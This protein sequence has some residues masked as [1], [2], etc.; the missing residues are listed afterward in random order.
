M[1]RARDRPR[2]NR[3]QEK[4]RYMH[5]H[6]REP[7]H[8]L[9]TTTKKN[10]IILSLFDLIAIQNVHVKCVHAC[11]LCYFFFFSNCIATFFFVIIFV[12]C[13]CF[14]PT[15][16]FLQYRTHIFFFYPMRM[17]VARMSKSMCILNAES[18][19]AHIVY[20]AFPYLPFA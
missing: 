11:G 12:C 17:I 2:F 8:P 20:Y 9:S 15:A 10:G 7:K 14:F 18:S 3:A 19:S 4:C 13:C 1:W 16:S 6:E 5:E